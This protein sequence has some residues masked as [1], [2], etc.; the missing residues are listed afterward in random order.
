M[1]ARRRLLGAAAAL[2]PLPAAADPCD[3]REREWFTDRVLV[4][5][6]GQRRRFYAD[7]LAGR[8]VLLG[9]IFTSCTDSCPLLAARALAVV[10]EAARLGAPTR[11]VHL[12][13]DPRRDRPE[14]LKAW[15]AR[16]GD[17][18]DWL[19]L[20][21]AAADLREVS[22]RLGQQID[23][24]QPDRHGTMFLAGNVPARRWAR[25]RP[26][27]PEGAAALQLSELAAA[28][29]VIEAGACAS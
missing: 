12:T 13:S 19:L 6:H 10:E 23:E 5:Q 17:Y 15:A 14:R 29:A 28:P 16:F 4:D 2:L 26:D 24:A 22:R 1:I 21:G 9:W 20:T 8:S 18:P 11:L 27:M 25:I 7:V 3:R